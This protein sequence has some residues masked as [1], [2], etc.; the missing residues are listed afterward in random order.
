[1]P[2]SYL[3]DF[4]R[5]LDFTKIEL[6]K[7]TTSSSHI[8]PNPGITPRK[9][10]RDHL[11]WQHAITGR[12]AGTR[13]WPPSL[14]DRGQHAVADAVTVQVVDVSIMTPDRQVFAG[15]VSIITGP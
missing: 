14:T 15:P 10:D 4:V 11:S 13:I 6:V 7:L 2:V 5:F 1:V 8:A 9:P 12:H 3:V